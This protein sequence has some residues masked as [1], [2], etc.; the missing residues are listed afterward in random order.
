MKYFL[1]NS[2]ISECQYGFLPNRSTQEAIFELSKVIYSTINNRKLMG[3]IFLDVAKAFNCIH[4][5]RLYNK[6]RNA[7]CSNR[8]ISWFTSYLDRSQ[9]VSYNDMKSSTVPVTSGI[10]QGTVLGPLIFIF[11]INDIVLSLSR[12]H[13]SMFADDCVMYMTGNNCNNV[14]AIIQAELD[15]FVNWFNMNGLKLNTS[16][17]K[18]MIISTHARLKNLDLVPE[19]KIN[20]KSVQYVKQYNYLG[21]ILDNE[22]SLCPLLKN[23]KKRVNNRMFQLRKICKY[24]TNHA[25][26]LIYKQTI[27]PIFDYPGFL[28]TSLNSGDKHD[29]QVIQNDALRFAKSLKLLDMIPIPQLHNSVHLL[30]LE[31]RR[32]KQ[33]LKIMFI[34]AQKGKSRE[35]TNVNT[36]SQRK[37][38]FKT[39]TKISRKYEKSCYYLGTRLW[40][41]LDKETQE[42]DSIFSF[43]KKLDKLY[44]K[45]SPLL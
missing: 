26:T 16:K 17:T 33:L 12:C 43:R 20:N 45:Y 23:I 10:A 2:L 31:Q 38:V 35:V 36:R 3:L 24:I 39:E 29:L 27:L 6:L 9:M 34:H 4:H 30:S 1:D 25:A 37:Y 22:M 18:A 32:Q 5:D 41:V 40:N 13:I 44:K 7:G 21:V 28:L 8:C 14:H 42:S 15:A 11:Y 19:F